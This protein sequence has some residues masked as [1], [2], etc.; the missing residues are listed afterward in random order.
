MKITALNWDGWMNSESG[1]GIVNLEYPTALIRAGIDVTC[2]W[3]RQ[4]NIHPANFAKLTEQQQKFLSKPF[5]K[6]HIGIIKTTPEMFTKC[7]SEFR[8]GYSMVENTRI[9]ER[10]M[11][12]C[13][14]M[15]AMFVPSAY[16][17]DVFKESGVKKPIINVKQGLDQRRFKYIKRNQ[18]TSFIFGTVGYQDDR[19]NWKDLVSA[20]CSEFAPDEPV[21][22][23]IKNSNGYWVDKAFRDPRIKVINVMYTFDEV[24][25]IYSY[26][27]CFVFPSHA[28]GS[29]LPPREAMATGLPC[30]LTNWSGLTEIA[31]PSISYPLTPVAIDYPDVR[32]M[33]QPGFMARLDVAEIMYWM[34]YVYEHQDEARE[35]GKKASEFI[36]KN[37]NWDACAADLMKKL[38]AL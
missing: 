31:D 36:I 26:F 2:E 16:L 18:K 25:Q 7:T 24:R 8:I 33:E 32:G 38:E 35:K 34:R 21:E 20:F 28:E 29:G 11:N 5:R 15:D 19:K 27:D 6:Q 23:W 10:W 17:I 22:L 12:W 3:E 37:Y 9:G 14:D 4:E 13:N 1:Y 30:I